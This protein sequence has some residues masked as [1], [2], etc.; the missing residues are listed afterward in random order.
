MRGLKEIVAPLVGVVVLALAGTAFAHGGHDDDGGKGS[1]AVATSSATQVGANGALLQAFVDAKD[2]D[3]DFVFE[4]GTS[5]SYGLQTASGSAGSAKGPRAVS[6]RV[7]GLAP[8]TTYH[9]RVVATNS[10]GTTQGSN[11]SFTTLAAAPDDSGPAP[12]GPSG[13]SGPAGVEPSIEPQLG[14]SVGVASARGVIRVRAKG[15]E[16]FTTLDA[17]SELPMGSE[18]DARAGALTLTSALPSGE[19]QTGTF[20]GGRFVIQQGRRGYVDLFLRGHFCKRPGAGRRG[21]RPAA[22]AAAARKRGRR[23]WGRDKGGRFRTHGRNSHATVRGTRWSVEDRCDG[24][25]TRVS[26]GAVVVSD[27]VRG[28]RKVVRAGERY[29]ARPRR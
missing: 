2:R 18:V 25:L 14:S 15:S 5:S 20:G 19:E 4:Y 27:L 12:S 29:L 3:T 7:D 9:F 11:R 28:K 23:L 21:A 26:D 1:P 10:K 13:P 16:A 8:A 24:T 17:G 6:M 22:A